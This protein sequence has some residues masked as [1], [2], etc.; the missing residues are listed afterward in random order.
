MGYGQLAMKDL[1][2]DLQSPNNQITQQLRSEMNRATAS[3][4]AGLEDLAAG[5]NLS[6]GSGG[7]QVA[8]GDIYESGLSEF[9][10]GLTSAE[11][12]RLGALVPLV[13]GQAQREWQAAQDKKN[14]MIALLSAIF[15]GAVDI[16]TSFLPIP[17]G[18]GQTPT[19]PA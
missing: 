14:R 2:M 4:M 12:M 5:R 8:L 10:K 15:G 1:I 3:G 9:G 17:G 16:G 13:G 6:A 18:G 19:P 11:Q 7:Y